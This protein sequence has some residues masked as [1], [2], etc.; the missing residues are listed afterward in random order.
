VLFESRFRLERFQSEHPDWVF[1]T[2]VDT[3]VTSA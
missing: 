1:L 2:T 3:G